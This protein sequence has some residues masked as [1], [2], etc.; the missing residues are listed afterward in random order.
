MDPFAVVSLPQAFQGIDL[1][2]HGHRAKN[3]SQQ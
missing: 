3:G 2:M 1:G